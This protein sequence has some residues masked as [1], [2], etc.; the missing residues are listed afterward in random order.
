M[1][2][3]RASDA[4]EGP[5]SADYGWRD[6]LLEQ[7]GI[8]RDEN[9]V[10]TNSKLGLQAVYGYAG[11]GDAAV[12]AQLQV[13]GFQDFSRRTGVSYDDLFAIVKTQFINPNGVLIRRIER[14]NAS[15]A[16]LQ[17]LAT[18]PSTAAQFIAELPADLDP[19]EYGGNTRSDVVRWVLKNLPRILR[20]ITIT[21]PDPTGDVD[22]YDPSRL[23]FRYANPNNSKNLLEATDFLKIIRFIRLWR[24]LGL[25]IEQTDAIL[26]ALYPTTGDLDDGSRTLLP[27]LGFLFQVINSLNLN[28]DMDLAQLL[29]CW[30]PIGTAGTNSLYKMLFLAPTILSRDR[31][32]Q[33]ATVVG[34][35]VAGDVLITVIDG[36]KLSYTVH[37]EDVAAADSIAAIAAKIAKA[38]NANFDGGS[39][40][41][42][43]SQDGTITIRAGFT[44]ALS[45]SANAQETYT[46]DRQS[47]LSQTA[48][49]GGTA[50]PGDVLTTTIDGLAIPYTVASGDKP[51]TIAA[52]IAL[53]INNAT[54]PDPFSG[55]PLNS[56]VRASSKGIIV[57][58][59]SINSGAPFTLAC[60]LS[61]C[62]TSGSGSYTSAQQLSPFADDGYGNFLTDELQ[63]L[64]GHE[65]ALRAACNLTGAEFSLI[66]G[67]LG[68]GYDI[69]TSLSLE[70]VSEVFRFGWLA[71]KLRISILEFLLLRRFSA[72]D[73]FI[74]LDPG[75]APPIEPPV[76]RL[77]RL[78]EAFAAAGLRPVQALYLIWN[79][80][81]S[82][83]SAPPITDVTTLARTLR[84]DFAEVD[85]QF[86]L[87]ADPDSTIAKGLMALVYGNS[88]TE[89]FFDLLNNTL[90]TSIAYSNPP[91]QSRLPQPVI[92]ASV[93]RLSYDDFRKM[94]TYTGVLDAATQKA[95][96]K[97]VTDNGNYGPLHA[98]LAALASKN[99]QA[100]GPFFSTYPELKPLYDAYVASGNQPP[101]KRTALLAN[102]LP[103][104]KAKR[105][106]EQAL[107]SITATTGTDASF[108]PALLQDVT[109]LHAAGTSTLA[110]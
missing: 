54:E 61:P 65:S 26:G 69:T 78:V 73:P 97:A 99:K 40:I 77:I 3:L 21:D 8:S 90:A 48:T 28:P 80:D 24:K 79:Q 83:K 108:A 55:L 50:I 1:T 5:T 46:A 18:D 88:V 4:I 96:D 76:I 91:E 14:L 60:T 94:L 23:Q 107:A 103:G 93:G 86:T 20:L 52:N 39:R 70:K 15:F 12:L 35:V 81:I 27:R 10:F 2:A 37:P 42:A 47:P 84:A 45:V 43:S 7:L 17:K 19:R 31:G 16:T 30:A 89:F 11:I 44:L 68:L 33:T 92:D 51:A 63:T 41:F 75:T 106:Q 66:M 57:T 32:Q 6:I 36:V 101:A 53:A 104:L 38:I 59:D 74:Q 98:A 58:I 110:A 25:T 95:I 105:K 64:F 87:V 9:Q 102:F 49:V 56:L 34:P 67:K 29:A 71:R 13:T 62:D 72:L 85:T 100:V 22:Q 109:V 82:G